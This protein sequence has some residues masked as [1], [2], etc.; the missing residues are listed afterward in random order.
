MSD[1]IQIKHLSFQYKRSKIPALHDIDLNVKQNEIIGLVGPNGAGKST[2]I[3]IMEGLLTAYTGHVQVLETNE[4]KHAPRQ[5]QIQMGA[6]FQSSGYLDNLS[7]QESLTLFAQMYSTSVTPKQALAHMHAE[8][9]LPKKVK[10]LSGGQ[11]QQFGIALSLINQPKLLFLDEPTTGLD[12][13]A[14]LHLWKV[15]KQLRGQTTTIICSHYMEEVAYL[16][17]RVCFINEGQV[18]ATDTPSGLI[19][20][21]QATTRIEFAC[22]NLSQLITGQGASLASNAH[23]MGENRYFIMTTNP[24]EFLPTLYK[25][26]EHSHLITDIDVKKPTLNDAYYKITGEVMED[27]S[28]ETIH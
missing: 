22:E 28:N 24:S 4:I 3:S 1:I 25:L 10:N 8:E 15:I 7:V 27:D 16:C 21:S 19:Q 13:D 17:D 6:L 5:A 26:E 2:L 11:K 18:Y 12:P 14:R 23:R 9:L 20:R